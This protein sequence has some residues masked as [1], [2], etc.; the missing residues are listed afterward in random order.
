M[1]EADDVSLFCS[2]MNIPRMGGDESRRS[3][4]SMRIKFIRRYLFSAG[5]TVVKDSADNELLLLRFNC[6]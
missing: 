4:R 6:D 3:S 5:V 2:L 1:R